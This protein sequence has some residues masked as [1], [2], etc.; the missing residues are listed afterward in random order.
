MMRGKI[1]AVCFFISV[2]CLARTK[3]NRENVGAEKEITYPGRFIDIEEKKAKGKE[4]AQKAP[5]FQRQEKEKMSFEDFGEKYK[6]G[7]FDYQNKSQ[8]NSL[9]DRVFEKIK[10][11]LRFFAQEDIKVEDLKKYLRVAMYALAMAF[12]FILILRH[13]GNWFFQKRYKEESIDLKNV[14]ENLQEANFES[15]VE[16][17]EKNKNTK[18]SIRLYYLWLLKRLWERGVICYAPGKTNSQYRQEI[19]AESQREVFGYLSKIYEYI[20]YGNFK[21]S[22]KEYENAKSEFLKYINLK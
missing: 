15:L 4:L 6:K 22:D 7:E 9:W 10:D 1:Y 21:I 20:W 3:Q 12:S 17:S 5:L 18:E 8:N 13:K 19:K 11:L 2:A 16:K 14:E